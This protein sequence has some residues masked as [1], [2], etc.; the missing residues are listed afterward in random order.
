MYLGASS[1]INFGESFVLTPDDLEEAIFVRPVG[2]KVEIFESDVEAIL[3][4]LRTGEK[5]PVYWNITPK[6]ENFFDWSKQ[7]SDEEW[8]KWKNKVRLFIIP[9]SIYILGERMVSKVRQLKEHGWVIA[10]GHSH[11]RGGGD[12]LAKMLGID[13]KNCMKPVIEEG[14]AKKFDQSVLEFFTNLY[15]STMLVHEDPLSRDYE[16]KKKIIEWLAENMA[17]RL[18]RLFANY[19]AF[20]RGQVPSG[21]WNTSHM[22]SWIMAMYFCLFG[23]WQIQNA[24]EELQEE[25][26]EA[27]FNI[28]M[29]I[30]YGDDHAW[31]KGEGVSAQY[32]SA[33]EFARFCKKYFDVDVRD[34]VTGATFL[35]DTFD[36]FLVRKGLTFLRHQFIMNPEKGQGQC[37][38]I[39]F[40]EWREFLI[41]AVWG[42][43]TSSRDCLSVMMS[44]I[45][46]AYGTY[47]SNYPAYR[48]LFL[49]FESLVQISGVSPH[50]S[51]K[52]AIGRQTH[53]DLKKLRQIGISPEE[54]LRGFPSWK[55]LIAK[56]VMDWNY[57]ETVHDNIDHDYYGTEM[58]L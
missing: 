5:P 28:I 38:F 46:H 13:L 49:L 7:C 41:R 35:S 39:P 14:D 25:L 42:R 54:V 18:T 51:L 21:C 32:F 53:D 9:S 31:N 56:N 1:G 33:D 23:L 26:E 20:V 44:C 2:K 19:W 55:T 10:V 3:N 57:H 50:I 15:F 24:P 16:M 43:E 8:I 30:V 17:A 45:G 22:D 12:V 52:E 58:V 34:L 47:A 40:R 27:L 37:N 11:S 48:R 29:I 4:F 36:G 6:N